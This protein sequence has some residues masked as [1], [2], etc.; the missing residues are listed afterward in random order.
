MLIIYFSCHRFTKLASNF[1]AHIL[2]FFV[3]KFLSQDPS[4]TL[5]EYFQ[6]SFSRC[7]STFFITHL[8]CCSSCGVKSHSFCLN[9]CSYCASRNH[10]LS[11]CPKL[12]RWLHGPD[13]SHHL[14]WKNIVRDWLISCPSPHFKT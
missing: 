14:L 9:N 1:R 4:V 11:F 2:Y 6:Y 8:K 13:T 3:T 7:V 5:Q 10:R 12:L